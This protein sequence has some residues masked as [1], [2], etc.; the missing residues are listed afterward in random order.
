MDASEDGIPGKLMMSPEIIRAACEEAHS[1][2]LKVAT[3]VES[4]EGMKEALKNSVDYIEHEQIRTR[5]A[6]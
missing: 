2:D 3:H 5:N 6:S 1:L 4:T